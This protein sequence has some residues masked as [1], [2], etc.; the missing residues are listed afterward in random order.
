MRVVSPINE[1]T[2]Y[3]LP[4]LLFL[5]ERSVVMP[6]NKYLNMISKYCG[7]IQTIN[8]EK[9]I[10]VKKI[11]DS[12]LQWINKRNSNF[13]FPK[14][15]NIGDVVYIEFGKNIT[16]EISYLHMGIVLY[17]KGKYLYV[18]PITTKNMNNKGHIN[19]YHAV[20]KSKNYD[21]CFILMKK[22]EFGFLDHDSVVKAN[23][24]RSISIKR[25]TVIKGTI[26]E[27]TTF[28]NTIIE[29]TLRNIL[30]D[31]HFELNELRKNIL[32]KESELQELK[33][34]IELLESK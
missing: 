4:V 24:L 20:D 15:Y 11:A 27:N 23:D 17:R 30:P 6:K 34:K 2:G 26:K 12:D 3:L 32:L 31:V 16:P 18:V 1:G 9:E 28:F 33:N 25:A 14:T 21:K 8:G 22:N 13:P 10:E 19:A 29:M 7:Y 5:I